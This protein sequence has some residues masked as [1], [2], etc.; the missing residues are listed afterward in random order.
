MRWPGAGWV[1]GKAGRGGGGGWERESEPV[2]EPTLLDESEPETETEDR[3]QRQEEI[4][5]RGKRQRRQRK[6]GQQA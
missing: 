5:D 1:R 6:K 4:E 2:D 3:G